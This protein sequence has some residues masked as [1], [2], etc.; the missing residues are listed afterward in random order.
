MEL[1]REAAIKAYEEKQIENKQMANILKEEVMSHPC[2]LI[3]YIYI[4]NIPL[5]KEKND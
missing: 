3:K 2:N 4:F 5:G 1:A